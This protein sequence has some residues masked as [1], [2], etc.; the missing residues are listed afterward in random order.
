MLAFHHWLHRRNQDETGTRVWP[1]VVLA[2]AG[3]ATLLVTWSAL[4]RWKTDASL[5]ADAAQRD[6]NHAEAHLMLAKLADREKDY[7]SAEAHYRKAI[8]VAKNATHAVYLSPF[9]ARSGLGTSLYRQGRYA[10]SLKEFQRAVAIHPGNAAAHYRVGLV[11]MGGNDLETAEQAF[12]KSLALKPHDSVVIANLAGALLRR[13]DHEG[14]L[15]IYEELIAGGWDTPQGLR[16]YASVLLARERYAEARPIFE[17][18]TSSDPDDALSLAKL[19]WC[20]NALGEK[21]L[22]RVTLQAALVAEPANPAI[23]DIARRLSNRAH[24]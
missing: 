18:I 20:Q 23:R 2:G 22:A 1:R 8:A 21:K 10:E 17:R 24:R 7:P 6:P 3:V 19:A 11:A 16:K 13:G 12:R 15:E 5:F 4:P 9:V 14:Y